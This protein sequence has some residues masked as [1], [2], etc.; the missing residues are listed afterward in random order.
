[1][2]VDYA[3][4]ILFLENISNVFLPLISFIVTTTHTLHCHFYIT[5]A[6]NIDGKYQISAAISSKNVHN[7]SQVWD[8]VSK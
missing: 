4:M 8:Q 5:S 2:R 1:M 3:Y 6:A 7:D